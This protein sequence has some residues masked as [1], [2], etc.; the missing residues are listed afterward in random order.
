MLPKDQ[1]RQV[2]AREALD[3]TEVLL[4]SLQGVQA[5]LRLGAGEDVAVHD[6]VQRRH[7]EEDRRPVL[8]KAVADAA[9]VVLDDKVG[10]DEGRQDD[11][12]DERHR[13]VHRQD[14]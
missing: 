14:E 12:G 4:T 13:V 10:A 5:S 11:R 8:L 3:G 2:D 6:L 7:A 9:Q 1:R